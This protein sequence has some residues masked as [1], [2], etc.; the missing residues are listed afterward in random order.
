MYI[1]ER[2]TSPYLSFQAGRGIVVEKIFDRP[3]YDVSCGGWMWYPSVGVRLASRQQVDFHFDL[4]YK[5]Q[6]VTEEYDYPNDWWTTS[7]LSETNNSKSFSST[8]K[9]SINCFC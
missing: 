1:P 9:R 8:F 5:F 7:S 6:Q 3:E 4:G 2:A